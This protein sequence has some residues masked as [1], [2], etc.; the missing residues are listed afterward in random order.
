MQYQVYHHVPLA[1]FDLYAIGI[2]LVGV[3]A[4]LGA[5]RLWRYLY[6]SR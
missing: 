3:M 2:V 4:V 5:R 6:G 1:N